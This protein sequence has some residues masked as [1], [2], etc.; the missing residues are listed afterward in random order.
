VSWPEVE[1]NVIFTCM[2]LDLAGKDRLVFNVGEPNEMVG[3]INAEKVRYYGHFYNALADF[4]RSD[5][6]VFIFNAGDPVYDKHDEFTSKVERLFAS[7]PD[8]WVLA[9]SFPGGT[10]FQDWRMHIA[11][12]K[13]HQEDGLV[14][15]SMTDGIWSALR[16]EVAVVLYEA[17]AW[18]LKNNILDFKN[19]VSGWGVDYCYCAYAMS[20]GRKVYRDMSVEMLHKPGSSYSGNSMRELNRLLAGFRAYLVKHGREEDSERVWRLFGF[21]ND[22]I[23]IGESFKPSLPEIFGKEID[24]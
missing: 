21:I 9:P 14:L 16:R 15:A 5:A 22:K 24:Y 7:D 18:M 11:D 2:Q 4:V 17:M 10:L 23:T 19:M 20:Q 1:K 12:S 3:W 8:L 13:L 6:E